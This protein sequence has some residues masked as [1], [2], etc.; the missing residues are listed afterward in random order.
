MAR[1]K[2]KL[3][4]FIAYIVIGI[5]IIICIAP[6]IWIVT[7]SFKHREVA[8]AVPPA[9]IWT[10]TVTNYVELLEEG[11]L[12][13]LFNS[14]V[15]AGGGTALSM[16]LG[17]FAAYSFARFRIGG[18]NLVF[19]ILTLRMLPAVVLALPLFLVARRI[20]M[21]DNCIFLALVYTAFNLPLVIWIMRSFISDLP[22]EMEEAAI[23]DG[24]GLYGTI[25]RIVIPLVSPG[26]AATAILCFI[27]T[28]NELT[29]ALVLTRFQGA[30][31]PVQTLSFISAK[32]IIWGKMTAA[33]S[34]IIVPVLA[35][36]IIV[37]KHIVRGLT[38][39]AVR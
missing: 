8:F 37:Q 7:T 24:C 14:V 18:K 11:F 12:K 25:F 16:I 19:W 31:L 36:S 28:W 26:I 23:I 13:F 4:K 29:I 27:L 10:P 32:G 20:G 21:V 34:I 3:G 9:L 6:I 35:F 22:R 5:V 15:A 1:K 2:S 38:F 17:L 33:S 30:T 39:G